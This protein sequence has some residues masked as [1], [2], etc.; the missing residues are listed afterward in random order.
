MWRSRLIALYWV[1]MRFLRMPLLSE[2]ES[3][4]SMMR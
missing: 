3:V 1:K 4:K 2:L